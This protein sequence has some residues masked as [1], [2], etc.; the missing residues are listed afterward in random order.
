MPLYC[1]CIN[2][3]TT[4]A[5]SQ[6][7]IHYKSKQCING[8]KYVSLTKCRYCGV[9]KSEF[10]G[11]SF[12]T[13]VRNC[14]LNP[15]KKYYRN[16]KGKESWCKGLTKETDVRVRNMSISLSNSIKGKIPYIATDE[17]WTTER[18]DE[19]SKKA[20]ERN[21][22]TQNRNRYA[23]GYYTSPSAGTV[24][25]E[26]SYEFMVANILDENGIKWIRPSPLDYI[27][28]GKT[29]RYFPDFLLCDFKIYLDPK[30]D[31][32][33]SQD[34]EKI[35]LVIEQNNVNIIVLPIQNITTDYILTI[36][37]G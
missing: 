29:K 5:T 12:S 33:I 31:Y 24:W 10:H 28:N 23:H 13:H 22:G 30:N 21:F 19:F 7:K 32:L 4:I 15:N 27:L 6:L 37:R 35:S 18:R 2:C 36:I 16:T 3:K 1:S 11:R 17:F 20:L 25:L 34:T 14:E 8:G 26:S 9:D